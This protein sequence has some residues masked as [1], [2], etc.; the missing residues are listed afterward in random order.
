MKTLDSSGER[1]VDDDDDGVAGG[2]EAVDLFIRGEETGVV[3]NQPSHTS[4]QA[5]TAIFCGLRCLV[6]RI[7]RGTWQSWRVTFTTPR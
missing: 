5:F 7:G 1:L 3:E 6:K 2:A 4:T